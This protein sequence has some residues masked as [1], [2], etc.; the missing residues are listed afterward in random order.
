M[1]H[2]INAYTYKDAVNKG[3]KE[4]YFNLRKFYFAVDVK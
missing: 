4:Q 3:Y 1:K 2:N